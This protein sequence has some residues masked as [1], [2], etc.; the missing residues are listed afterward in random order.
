M[1]T[2]EASELHAL[3]TARHLSAMIEF[4]ERVTTIVHLSIHIFLSTM[5]G[6][7]QAIVRCM[8]CACNTHIII[9]AYHA[10]QEVNQSI[11]LI[12]VLIIQ[13]N[14]NFI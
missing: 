9:I 5:D 1:L 8:Q 11:N 3:A 12:M 2:G 7:R 10:I 13:L 6:R 4:N 14:Y